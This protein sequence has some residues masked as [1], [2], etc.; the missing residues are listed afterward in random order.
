MLEERVHSEEME[1]I[2]NL[3]DEVNKRIK[4]KV[5]ENQNCGE[6]CVWPRNVY[7]RDMP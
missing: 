3:N 5:E 7:L 6:D 4:I 1:K 2:S